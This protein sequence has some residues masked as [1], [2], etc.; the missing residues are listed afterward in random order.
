L[1][2]EKTKAGV[3]AIREQRTRAAPHAQQNA[4]RLY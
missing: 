3:R 2:L 1:A 4:C